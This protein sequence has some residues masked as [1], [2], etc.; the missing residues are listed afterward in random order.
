MNAKPMNIFDV[1]NHVAIAVKSIMRESIV[2]ENLFS[3][4]S[5]SCTLFRVGYG[6]IEGCV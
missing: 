6:V 2:R 5:L 3:C 4:P 1:K